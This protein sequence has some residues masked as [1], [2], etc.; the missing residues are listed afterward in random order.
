MT[1]IRRGL[2]LLALTAAVV[3]AGSAGSAFASF[4]DTA[5]ISLGTVSTANVAAPTSIVGHVTCASPNATM[6]VTW[7]Q[8]PS[9]RISGYRVSVYFSDGF[10]QTATVASSA[11]S[12]SVSTSLFNV[13]AYSVRYSVTTLTDYGWTKESALTGSFQC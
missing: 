9:I 4:A 13:T 12:W 1:R 3:L 5:S 2:L 6:Q 8:S 7:V 10:V 11:T